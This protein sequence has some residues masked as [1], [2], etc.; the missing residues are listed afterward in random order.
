MEFQNMEFTDFT[1]VPFRLR[2][3]AEDKQGLAEG[4]LKGFGLVLERQC[5]L[6]KMYQEEEF[7]CIGKLKFCKKKKL[8]IMK[9]VS[10]I[11]H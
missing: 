7:S 4:E 9:T 10:F 5:K 3:Y 11:R 8:Y 6:D 1:Q 2:P